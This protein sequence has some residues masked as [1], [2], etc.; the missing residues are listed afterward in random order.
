MNRLENKVAI[1]TGA[2]SG[3]GRATAKLFASEGATVVAAD[4]NLATAQETVDA[5]VADGGLALALQTDVGKSSDCEKMVTATVN[6]YGRV[7]VL[8]NN[9]G[10]F[11]YGTAVDLSEDQW[12]RLLDINLKGPFLC[13]K[14]AIPHMQAQGGGSI[15]CISSISGL[16]AQPNHLG[17]NTSKF[18]V[19]GLA[20]CMA[21]D[22]AGD[23]IR[24]NAVCPGMMDT[25]MLAN[26]T[27][28]GWD[29]SRNK[30]M[31]KRAADPIEVASAVLYLASDES[32]FTTGAVFVVDGGETAM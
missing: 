32:S 3:L 1:V 22:F 10:I 18:A 13:S 4:I 21:L 8:V 28:E 29:Q 9:A 30:N 5:I 14:F 26:V 2:G 16:L 24:V 19:I 20:K 25:N 6:Q 11:T 17:Y 7:D 12:D 31:M 27:Q 15:V 23:N